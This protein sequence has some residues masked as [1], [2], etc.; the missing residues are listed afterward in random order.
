MKRTLSS[1]LTF[2]MK[3]IFPPLWIGAFSVGTLA[4]FLEPEQ[5]GGGGPPPPGMGL[6]FLVVTILGTAFLYWA[7]IRLK[8]VRLDEEALHISNYL[9]EIRVPLEQVQDITESVWISMHP[10]RIELRS[11]TEFGERIVFMPRIR[12]FAFWSSHPVVAEI[13]EAAARMRGRVPLH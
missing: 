9:R 3:V 7:C 5:S 11:E 2:F 1:R 12:P 6:V 4:I 13:R 10:V 8:R